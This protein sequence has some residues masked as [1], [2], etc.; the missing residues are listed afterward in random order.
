MAGVGDGERRRWGRGEGGRGRWQ[1]PGSRDTRRWRQGR[2]HPAEPPGTG[3]RR[4]Q[5]GPRPESSSRPGP[6]FEKRRE[7][8][9]PG[10]GE[11]HL[12]EKEVVALVPPRGAPWTT[13]GPAGSRPVGVSPGCCVKAPVPARRSSLLVL[14]PA[15]SGAGVG[16]WGEREEEIGNPLYSP[17]ATSPAPESLSGLTFGLQCMR[18][19]LLSALL[20]TIRCWILSFG[21]DFRWCHAGDYLLS[22]TPW[23]SHITSICSRNKH[24]LLIRWFNSQFLQNLG[25]SGV[26]EEMALPAR[27]PAVR[28]VYTLDRGW[29]GCEFP[30]LPYIFAEDAKSPS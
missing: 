29:H 27:P 19:V 6:R 13:A 24:R 16:R 18:I 3:T 23:V 4:G 10:L 12:Q 21:T 1:D 30:V 22:W 17:G 11:A 15:E 7:L 2:P 26:V 9:L 14:G 8:A 20:L 28:I 25:L 5:K